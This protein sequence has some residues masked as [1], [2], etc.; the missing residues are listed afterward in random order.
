[1][2]R[3]TRYSIAV[4][5]AVIIIVGVRIEVRDRRRHREQRR[6][7][8]DRPDRLAEEGPHPHRFDELGRD[9][10]VERREARRAKRLAGWQAIVK[11][12]PTRV[13]AEDLPLGAALVA[14]LLAVDL[15]RL[16]VGPQL[17]AIDL[18]CANLLT[19]AGAN[20]LAIN[21]RLA[22]D[23]RSPLDASGPL[24]DALLALDTLLAL[25]A[26]LALNTRGAF[27]PLDDA[28]LALDT[29]GAFDARRTSAR[30]TRCRSTRGARSAR[31]T[32]CR[33][34]RGARSAR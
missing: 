3:S 18:V 8:G 9:A 34:T 5:V 23:S 16:A 12:R 14:P 7:R 28:L 27:G 31:W 30:W 22:F 13:V 2:S 17:G 26:L 6:E 4:A 10:V 20:L 32:R 29:L 11:T 15:K 21:A 25:D 19:L 24:L 1:M 33:S